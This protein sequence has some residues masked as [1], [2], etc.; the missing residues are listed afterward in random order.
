MRPGLF[1]LCLLF[2]S[3][4]S[5]WAQ[6]AVAPYATAYP[7]GVSALV[8][9][10]VTLSAAFDGTAPINYMWLKDG[11]AVAGAT[12]ATLTFSAPPIAAPDST[13]YSH[14]ELMA[15]NTAGSTTTIK[16]VVYIAKRPQTITF[17]APTTLA[18]AGSGITLSAT[19]SSNLPVTISLVSGSASL[20]G[21]VLN[22]Q[23][24]NVIVR[25]TQAGDT[26]F[27]AADP[28]DRT[29]SFVAGAL[30][31]F[32]TSPPS[33]QTVV[34]GSSLSLRVSAIGNPAPAYQWS[35]NNVALS[36]ATDAVFTLANLTLA[37][38][39][40][41]SVTAT[42]LAGTAAASAQVNVQAAPMF[43]SPPAAQTVAAGAAVTLSV[44][45]TG[46][47]VP[48]LQWRKNGTP[49][50]GATQSTY[51]LA[52]AV[53]TQAG[54]Y[55]VVATNSIGTTTSAT[56]T[57]TVISR[58]FNGT[59][60]GRFTGAGGD[61]V[62]YARGDGTA[63]FFGHLPTLPAGLVETAVSVS[64]A[65]ELAATVSLI[66]AT[67]REGALR[68]TID[69]AAGT[70]SGTIAD[71]GLAFT[72][73]RVNPGNPPPAAAGLYSAALVGSAS[74]RGYVII[75]A[76]GQ[77]F[78]ITAS[79][80]AVD[81]AR[82]NLNADNRLV[83]TTTSQAVVDL[84]FTGGELRGTVRT[85]QGIGTIA[86]AIEALIGAEHLVNLSVR[87]TTRNSDPMAAGFVIGGTLPKQVLIRAAGPALTRA[88]F[89][90]TGA[91]AN[92]SL[93]L[94]RGSSVIGQNSNW[95]TPASSAAAIAA[96]TA[97][98]GA[99]P[100]ANGSADS[101]L[102]AT[103][104]PGAYTVQIGGG[105]GFVLAEVYEVRAADEAPGSRRLINASTLGLV[106]PGEPIMAGFVIGGTAPQRV[107]IRATGP[108]LAR[109]PFNLDN[110]LPNPQLTVFRGSTPIATNDDWFR[111]PEAALIRT[112]SADV[113]AFAL[114]NQSLD[115]ALLTYLEPGAYTVQVSGPPNANNNNS[116]GVVLLEIYEATP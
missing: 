83:V 40:R 49:V 85:P 33:D 101:A 26:T 72:G 57:L 5:A 111:D 1:S 15:W 93:Q 14:Y 3:L 41:Y 8:G 10:I 9:D 6:P 64:L 38:T 68:G 71:L 66:A 55:D 63:A 61:F 43:I 18:A 97:R 89:N 80:S 105:N 102:L 39:A 27:A 76:D 53:R 17:A 29:I 114:Q 60:F 81:S 52:S 82:G 73:T 115:A 12:N 90:I 70:V 35:R 96:A 103:L 56:A 59:Y 23:G 20:N 87:G 48:T 44:E 107:L 7:T 16:V 30:S 78:V 100:F 109:A 4:G 11:G 65:G 104:P 36:G 58:D 116:T 21:R 46:Y 99:F 51:A 22:G 25:A 106:L 32:I 91:V 34:A 69:D 94:F 45:V 13:S 88:P 50:A 74:G 37:D 86:G 75:A 98:A 28:V 2:A 67:P 42:N 84:G 108:A 95:G 19:A 31:P 24:G 47:P 110:T 112:A 113:R 92:P 77:A 79:G 62:L 54:N